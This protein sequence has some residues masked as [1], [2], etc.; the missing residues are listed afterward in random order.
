MTAAGGF[1]DAGAKVFRDELHFVGG[2][3]AYESPSSGAK[4]GVSTS[5]QRGDQF[6]TMGNHTSDGDLRR[7]IAKTHI[8]R[9]G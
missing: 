2:E 5:N 8:G 1:Q 7:I 6:L 9:K 4:R 3:T